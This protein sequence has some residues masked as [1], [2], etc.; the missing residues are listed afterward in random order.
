MSTVLQESLDKVKAEL[1]R[2]QDRRK[3]ILAELFV[4]E[5]KIKAKK[6]EI[7]KK[8]R[9]LIV[10]AN[11]MYGGQENVFTSK[12]SERIAGSFF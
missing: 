7:L 8:E 10:A 9:D 2:E 1:A 4:V 6:Y 3:R 5:E 12:G 11:E